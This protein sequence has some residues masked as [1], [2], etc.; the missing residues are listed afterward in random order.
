M[1][2]VTGLSKLPG[3]FIVSGYTPSTT[4]LVATVCLK[5]CLQYM[6]QYLMIKA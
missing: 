6:L 3:E 5:L 4:G 1:L 2:P